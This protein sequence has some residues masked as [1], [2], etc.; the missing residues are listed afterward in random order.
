MYTIKTPV[1]GYTG[2]GFGIHFSNGEAQTSDER[3]ARTLRDLGYEVTSSE[4]S[5]SPEIS[6]NQENE[7]PDED[8][9][10]VANQQENSAGDT[11]RAKLAEHGINAQNVK[12]AET[13]QKM[14]DG[15][16]K[17][18]AEGKE[19]DAELEA[20]KGE[21]RELGVKMGNFDN[22]DSLKKKIAESKSE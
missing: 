4:V 18:I 11:L 20:L 8:G 17:K 14:L 12:S 9:K 2:F 13:L 15:V 6:D 10:G 21:A 3:I 22:V 7:Y 5:N 16:E 19:I 1:K